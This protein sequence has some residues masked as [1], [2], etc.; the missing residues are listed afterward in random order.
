MIASV[1]DESARES[2]DMVNIKDYDFTF[3]F[4]IQPADERAPLDDPE[5]VEWA[6]YFV[7]TIGGNGVEE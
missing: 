5:Y 6:P 4:N 3:A 1:I 7:T 2:T